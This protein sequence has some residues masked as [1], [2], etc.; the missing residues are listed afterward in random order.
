MSTRPRAAQTKSRITLML[1]V[2]VFVLP[3]VLAWIFAKGPLDW[4]PVETVN[5]GVLVEPPLLL[6][7]FGVM[8]ETGA[9]HPVDAAASDWFLVVLSGPA[10]SEQCAHWLQIAE[11]VQIAVGRDMP[12]VNLVLLGP[13]DDTPAL[14]V[15]E[16]Q[17]S[18][19]LSPGSELTNHWRPQDGRTSTRCK[20]AT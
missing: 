8:D 3:L 2:A 18:W 5:H 16:N 9:A 6:E 1:I 20:S 10:C 7:S 11:R 12:R 15:K 19:R 14:L 4:R 13:D 17:Q